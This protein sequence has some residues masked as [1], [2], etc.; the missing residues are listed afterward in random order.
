MN[1]LK[2]DYL[3]RK[4]KSTGLIN[5]FGMRSWGTCGGQCGEHLY[6]KYKGDKDQKEQYRVNFKLSQNL[7]DK[8]LRYLKRQQSTTRDLFYNW[9]KRMQPTLNVSGT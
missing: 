4:I 8:K 9:R 1:K 6:L 5:H 7:S 2:K 3:S